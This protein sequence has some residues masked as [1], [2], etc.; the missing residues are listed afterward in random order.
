LRL[1]DFCG[2]R[3]VE[4][5]PA[6]ATFGHLYEVLRTK[7]FRHLSELDVSDGEPYTWPDRQ[8]HHTLDVSNPESFELVKKMLDE[9][10]PLFSSDKVNICCDETFDLGRGK[11]R[12]LAEKAG[13]ERLYMDFLLKI[14]GAVRRHGKTALFWDDIL[15]DHPEF[16]REIPKDVVCLTWQYGADVQEEKIAGIHDIGLPQ[17]V[18][19]GISAWNRLAADMHNASQNISKSAE[20]AKKHEALGLLNTDWGDYGHIN[21]LSASIPGMILGAALAWNTGASTAQARM[22]NI[23]SAVEYGDKS[24]KAVSLQRELGGLACMGWVQLVAWYC[25]KF[26]DRQFVYPNYNV[27]DEVPE[28]RIV[29]C[30]R[31]ADEIGREFA[32]LSF[33]VD[34]SKKQDLGELCVAAQ[35]MALLN[36]ILLALKK[37]E[38]GQDVR[39]TVYDLP[40]LAEAVERWFSSY[41]AAW[42]LRN[43]ESELGRIR[44]V[45]FAVCDWLR[46]KS[47]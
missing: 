24:G 18:C 19:P 16:L 25:D 9:F 6:F 15:V 1:D 28:E 3:Y 36:A 37:Y 29:S 23:I 10:I 39:D 35:G 12:E 30:L 33:S 47:L 44:A 5:V 31:R 26:L 46:S 7:S 27:L 21:P 8:L 38:F 41:A 34:A 11:N 2:S 20:Y 14:I 40:G 43:R 22:D 45:F 17:Y 13:S 42:R 32:A 4:L